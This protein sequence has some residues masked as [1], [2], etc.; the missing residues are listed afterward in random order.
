MGSIYK[1]TIHLYAEKFKS[2]RLSVK[3]IEKRFHKNTSFILT[4]NNTMKKNYS[5]FLLGIALVV[6]QSCG[7]KTDKAADIVV[8]EETPVATEVSLS[9]TDKAAE[10]KI[11]IEKEKAE[12][13][14]KRRVEL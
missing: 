2:I 5:I 11:R 9:A 6:T 1:L 13:A 10:K 7:S 14:E 8:T 12:R 4:N 3:V